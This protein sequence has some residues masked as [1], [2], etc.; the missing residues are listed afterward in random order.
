MCETEFSKS[1]VFVLQSKKL[2]PS[3]RILL[4]LNGL[5]LGQDLW[6]PQHLTLPLGLPQNSPPVGW[7]SSNA[8]IAGET[9]HA[10]CQ[11]VPRFWFEFFW[12]KRLFEKFY[13][14]IPKVPKDPLS[15]T[16]SLMLSSL[17][18]LLTMQQSY[19][20]SPFLT[21]GPS[22]RLFSPNILAAFASAPHTIS[23]SCCSFILITASSFFLIKFQYPLVCTA[24][25]DSSFHTCL[26]VGLWGSTADPSLSSCTHL[27]K[28]P[29]LLGKAI[30]GKS[31]LSP[32]YLEQMSI[33]VGLFRQWNVKRPFWPE[34]CIYVF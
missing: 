13:A 16:V 30:A 31:C 15:L 34:V 14:V 3:C 5:E 17:S 2:S 28:R 10:F 22:S 24:C 25:M 23:T 21:P 8:A 11:W 27:Y 9:K 26:W 20:S 18:L 7:C 29:L 12:P 6:C 1:L 33:T 32:A 4:S 19:F